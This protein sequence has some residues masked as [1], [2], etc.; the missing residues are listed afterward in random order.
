MLKFRILKGFNRS[1]FAILALSEVPF[2]LALRMLCE[3]FVLNAFAR[4]SFLILTASILV[5]QSM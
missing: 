2:L 3:L 5:L 1:F 4:G